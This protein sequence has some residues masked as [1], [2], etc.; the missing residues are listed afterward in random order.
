MSAAV[1]H[2]HARVRGAAAASAVFALLDD[3]A[4]AVS[5]FETAPEEWRLEAYPQSPV[6]TPDLSARLA[7]AAAAGGGELVE[8]GEQKLPDRDWLTENPLAFAP[9]RIGRVF[10]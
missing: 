10:V 9:L 4:A 3:I 5:A 6:L 2:L 7:L 8:I 1:R